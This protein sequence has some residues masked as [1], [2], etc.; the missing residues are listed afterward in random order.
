MVNIM[1]KININASKFTPS[2]IREG[3]FGASFNK[4]GET[5]HLRM[6]LITEK[7]SDYW[8]QFTQ[9][10]KWVANARFRGVL[11]N[12]V[13]VAG[14]END[15]KYEDT[16]K[17][18]G[19]TE[20][21]FANFKEKAISFKNKKKDNLYLLEN[22]TTGSYF[23]STGSLEGESRYIV[24]ITKNENF[25]I[26]DVSVEFQDYSIKKYIEIYGDI[27]ISV[28]SDFTPTDYFHNRGIFRNPYWVFME[29][30][31]GLS[32]LLHGFIAAVA[33]LYFSEK[34]KMCVRPV[35][36]MQCI[37]KKNLL[38]GE[39]YVEKGDDEIDITDLEVSP[40][41][42]EVGM[43]HIQVAALTRIYYQTMEA[44]S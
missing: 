29:K 23:M 16:K 9:M 8:D 21:E 28:G 7:N 3:V 5:L 33:E 4:D 24:Y 38:P 12:H 31:A 41:D 11:T 25:S 44:L 30:Y 26:Q 40:D 1:N 39:G 15:W 6:E 27:L 37:I 42:P 2:I 36:G 18:T 10:T 32:M 20:E 22:T 14:T 13:R 35:G 19:F 17:V 43:N 34:M